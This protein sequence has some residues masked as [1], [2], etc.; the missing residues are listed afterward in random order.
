LREQGKLKE[1]WKA[2]IRES[3]LVGYGLS[4]VTFKE[5]EALN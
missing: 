3:K 5:K 2:F 4:G 1:K